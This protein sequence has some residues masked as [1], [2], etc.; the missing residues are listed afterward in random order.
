M[1]ANFLHQNI[2]IAGAGVMGA[3]I[4]QVA[5]QAGHPVLLFDTCDKISKSALESLNST[6]DLLV[7]RRKLTPDDAK[8]ALARIST[9]SDL[10]DASTADV[11]IEAIVEDL[12]EKRALLQTLELFV[13]SDCILASNTSSLSITQL[14][15][16]LEHPERLVGMHFFNPAPVMKLV[17][18]IFG[19]QTAPDVAE[20]S[21]QLAESWGKTPVFANSTPGFIVNRIARPFYAEALALLQEQAIKSADLDRCVRSAGFRMGPCE[22]MDLIGHDTNYKVTTSLFE[23]N[24]FDRR[25]T[26]SL[27][28]K[29]LIDA[30]FLGRK[31]GRGFFDYREP[32]K[33]SD[34]EFEFETESSVK[35]PDWPNLVLR[36][37]NW[38]ADHIDAALGNNGVNHTRIEDS[39][40]CEIESNGL[41]LCL[42]DGRMAS[43]IGTEVAVFDLILEPA[44]SPVVAYAVSNHSSAQLKTDAQIWLQMLG[45]KPLCIEDAAGLVV[46][47]TI[48]ML[49]NEAA[50][51]VQQDVCSQQAADIATQAGL[52]YPAGPFAWLK[53]LGV[54]YV[55]TLVENLDQV[56]RGERYRVSPWLLRRAT[57]RCTR[58]QQVGTV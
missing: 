9:T 26:P 5:A 7:D 58:R 6:F 44:N 48:A 57:V 17:E 20:Q 4:A 25:Y 45:F 40:A 11:V 41:K 22:L 56:Y 16:G 51:A 19:K 28:Q 10:S 43:Q 36:G 33:S 13:D 3:G 50:D 23:A 54:D 18:I 42:T 27:V 12:S 52:N 8:N 30:G 39:A 15:Q 37:S 38:I 49:I 14:G 35:V 34:H 31:S 47:R 24:Y 2:F 1:S 29:S 55:T 53:Q 46:A 32:G 21:F